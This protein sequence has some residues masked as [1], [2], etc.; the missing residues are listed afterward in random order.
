MRSTSEMVRVSD[1]M[2]VPEVAE[3]MREVDGGTTPACIEQHQ[4]MRYLKERFAE[5]RPFVDFQRLADY[6]AFEGLFPFEFHGFERFMTALFL[7]VFTDDGLPRWSELL[8]LSGRGTGKT[9]FDAY[10]SLCAM[11][12]ANGVRNYNVDVCA[13]VE[14]QSKKPFDDVKNALADNQRRVKGSFRWNDTVIRSLSTGSEMHYWTNNPKNRDSLRPGLVIYDEVHAYQDWKNINVFETGLGK[15]EH[16]R[17]M[18]STTDGDVREGVL[19]SLKERAEGI[20]AGEV[21]D[22]GLL[23]VVF[24]LDS[25]DEVHDEGLW[26]KANPRL[27]HSPSLMAQM[28]KEYANY[29][30][31]P[32]IHAS[33]MTKRMNRPQGEKASEVTSWE[34]ILATNRELPDLDGRPCVCGVDFARST[35][36]ISAVLLF[37][38]DGQYYAKHHSWFCTRSCD[39]G[40]I[41]APLDEWAARGIVTMVDDVE[42]SPEL[43]TSWIFEQTMTYDVVKV[44]I[45]DY[46]HTMFQRY[47]EEIGFSA[48]DGDVQ[49]IRP[50]DIMRVVPLVDSVFA[51]H[52]IAWGDDPCLRWMTNNTKLEKAPNNNFKYGKIEHRSRKTDGFMALVAAMCAESAIP[53]EQEVSFMPVITF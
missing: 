42:V 35:D 28:R 23:P 13:N 31:N 8:F 26:V 36:F 29:V 2:E 39:A 53:D 14:S 43:V 49:R 19:D 12:K 17:S 47:L 46:R 34:N 7:C 1:P 32:H 50:S 18:Y 3:W 51:Q 25:D 38:V 10:V 40:V 24:K 9:A 30:A 11:S 4:L 6:R 44:A 41:K 16:P 22:N 21:G 48:K 45:D 52:A 5:E 20:L 37:H 33:F 27:P 15:T